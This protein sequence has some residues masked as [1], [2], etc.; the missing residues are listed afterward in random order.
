MVFL[1]ANNKHTLYI[2]S[3]L[4]IICEKF[5]E[6][7]HNMEPCGQNT[8]PNLAQFISLKLW[9]RTDFQQCI[10]DGVFLLKLLLK[11]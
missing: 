5:T 2:V 4:L 3:E 1:M 11:F 8:K 10:Q 6:K 7:K 9:L